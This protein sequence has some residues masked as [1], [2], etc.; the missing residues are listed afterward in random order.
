MTLEKEQAKYAEKFG[1]FKSE[2]AKYRSLTEQVLRRLR[3]RY[4]KP[5]RASRAV[6]NLI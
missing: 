6:G 4:W 3:S 2:S 5:G 1:P